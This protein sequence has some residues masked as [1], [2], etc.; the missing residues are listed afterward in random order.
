[1]LGRVDDRSIRDPAALATRA[2]VDGHALAASVAEMRAAGFVTDDTGPATLTPAGTEAR[3]RLRV[4]WG[5]ELRALVADWEP[6][7]DP[8]LN[9]L[10]AR[11]AEELAGDPEPTRT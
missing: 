10:I 9:P 2:N 1:M 4:A 11:L 6:E 7:T 3:R 5:E 8:E